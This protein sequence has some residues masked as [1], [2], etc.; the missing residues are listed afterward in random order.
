MRTIV[1][2]AAML[3]SGCVTPAVTQ[4]PAQHVD[5]SQFEAVTYKV[6]ASEA[7]EYG[8]GEVG[9]KYG[10]GTI[11]LI[12][13]LLSAQLIQMGHKVVAQAEDHDLEIDINVTAAKPGSAAARFWVG[14]G[15]GRAVTLFDAKFTRPNGAVLASFQ[16]G[17]SYTGM[18]WNVSPFAGKSDISASAATRC[19]DQIETFMANG[20]DFPTS[21]GTSPVHGVA[22]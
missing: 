13:S 1:V 2:L 18:E 4:Y 10:R 20:G 7:V 22:N 14:F 11:A 19:V 12:D 3:L 15:A 16:G 5:F 6:H 8:D 9:L 17:R 21:K